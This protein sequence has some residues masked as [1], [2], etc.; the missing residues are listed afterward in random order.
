[1]AEIRD[2]STVVLVREGRAPF[3]VFMMRRA[4]GHEFMANAWVF[5]GGRIDERDC[6]DAAVDIIPG[7]DRPTAARC[8]GEEIDESTALGLYVA[9]L[10]ETFEEAGLLL[11]SPAG[12]EQ[13][14]AIDDEDSR[15][16]FDALRQKVDQGDLGLDELCRREGLVLRADRLIFFAH[17]ITP[18][19]ESRRYD[20][21]FFL[22]P[23]P[24]GQKPSHDDGE[25]TH[26]TWWTP[27]EAIEK[28][29]EDEILL[30][31]PTLRILEEIGTFESVDEL[32]AEL[33]KREH[34]PTILPHLLDSDASEVTLLLPGDPDYPWE[35]PALAAASPVRDDITRMIYRDGKWESE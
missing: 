23:A 27:A 8:L 7:L 30:A 11:A 28:Y 25:L 35:D 6:V 24:T 15:R 34:P 20:T 33:S 17:W 21:R 1:M 31:P 4:G 2:A 14:L 26:S 32:V 29:R 18:D 16:R 13:M 22:A 3:E 5:P 10:R 19:F 9:A 12:E